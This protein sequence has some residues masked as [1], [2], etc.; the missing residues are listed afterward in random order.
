[1]AVRRRK[2]GK[3]ADEA[4]KEASK[5]VVTDEEYHRRYSA[6]E[7]D[8]D[9]AAQNITLAMNAPKKSRWKSF[10][11][12]TSV[13]FAMIVWFLSMVAY[14]QQLGCAAIIMIAQVLVYKEICD[15]AITVQRERELPGFW[16]LYI[17]LVLCRHVFGLRCDLRTASIDAFFP[18]RAR[19][20]HF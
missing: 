7:D 14:T 6:T 1:M 17:S 3:G 9:T 11:V 8:T 10:T 13:G 15:V 20:S 16:L 5:L 4:S 2:I 19:I 12:R 18:Q